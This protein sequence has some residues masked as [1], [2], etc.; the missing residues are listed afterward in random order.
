MDDIQALVS[1]VVPAYNAEKYIAEAI[2]SVI[3]QTYNNWELIIIN[4]GSTDKTEEIIRDFEDNRITIFY[5]KNSGVCS[6]RNRGIAFAKGEYITF[7]DADDILPQKSLE[8]RVK[9]LQNNPKIDLVDGCISIKDKDMNTTIKTYI[10]Y[11]N[12]KLLPKLLKLDD[13]VFFNVCYFFRRQV[14]DNTLF[15][16]KM[17]HAEDLLFYIEI[18]SKKE[19]NYNFILDEIYLYRI[20]HTSA[21]TN[22][23]GL[24]KGYLQLIT[25]VKKFKNIS[26][27]DFFIFKCKIVKIMFLS[28]LSKK[29]INS[30]FNSIFN[31]FKI[32]LKDN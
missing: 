25:E 26:K 2:E 12:G 19:I 28:Y 8:L 18:S 30:A 7:L 6:A 13:R 16:E 22:L 20:G 29:K 15:K 10:P 27:L 4:D 21:M 32:K 11:Y 31:I 3:S 1:I 24:E 9:F 5:Q 14:L 17:T 23:H